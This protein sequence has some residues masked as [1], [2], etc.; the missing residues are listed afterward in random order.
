MDKID[1]NTHKDNRGLKSLTRKNGKKYTLRDNKDRFFFPDEYMKFEEDLKPRQKHSVKI[2]INTGAR[3][4]EVYNLKVDDCDLI[5]N[6]L[7]LRVTKSKAKK[8]EKK[9]RQRIIPISSQFSKYLKKYIRDNNLKSNDYLGVISNPALNIAYKKAGKKSGIKDY[10]NIASH[11]FRK[12]HGNW[13]KAIGIDGAEICTR[14]GHDYNTFLS[15]YSSP[16]IF[17]W[18]DKNKIREIL[19][20]LY[21]R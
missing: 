1:K 3:H 17:S 7:I 18:D 16:D 12:T 21:R 14:L 9:G 5:N 2:L 20:D 15:A 11:T 10:W 19:G 4:M 13:L 6:R 8:G